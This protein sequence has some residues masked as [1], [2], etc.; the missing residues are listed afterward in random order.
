MHDLGHGPFSD[1]FEKIGERF[2]LKMANHEAV[3]DILIRDSEIS[4]ELRDMGSGFPNDVADMVSGSGTP[5]IY[6]AVV[7]SWVVKD[8]GP[9]KSQCGDFGIS[10][11]AYSPLNI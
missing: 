1:A 3:S 2:E 4:A 6:S 5:T 9:H 11:C 8:I 10:C 7:S